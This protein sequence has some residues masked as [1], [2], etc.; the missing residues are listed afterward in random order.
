M[1]TEGRLGWTRAKR[2]QIATGLLGEAIMA[3][4]IGRTRAL[5][6]LAADVL[7]LSGDLLDARAAVYPILQPGA[8]E[9]PAQKRVK[10]A[11]AKSR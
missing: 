11:R 5:I 10:I 4:Q 9:S 7:N 3:P 2:A 8:M 1:V 6:K